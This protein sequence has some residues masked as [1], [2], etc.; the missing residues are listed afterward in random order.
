MH[1]TQIL[2]E[3]LQY[4]QLKVRATKSRVSLGQLLRSLI[5][6]YLSIPV[7]TT[8]LKVFSG[9]IQDSECQSTH[10]KKFLY[11]K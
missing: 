8:S 3:P 9:V 4:R 11:S 7:K 2:L 10:Y 1:R 5:D 6:Q